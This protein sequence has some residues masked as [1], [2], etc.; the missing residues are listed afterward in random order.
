MN[1]ASKLICIICIILASLA[2]TSIGLAQTTSDECPPEGCP[3][4]GGQNSEDEEYD[5][6]YEEKEYQA[7]QR[8]YYTF[9]VCGAYFVKKAGDN[10]KGYVGPFT[11]LEYRL[12]KVFSFGFDSFYAWL[13]GSGNQYLSV[14]NPGIKIY[15]FMYKNPSFEPFLFFGGHALDMILGDSNLG[16][17]GMAQGGF[18][19]AGFKLMPESAPVGFEF[20]TRVSFLAMQ[21]SNAAGG[22]RG[23]AIPIFGFLGVT[24]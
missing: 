1:M 11:N 15:P 16:K 5:F 20:F 9:G 12:M 13:S 21:R 10:V 18:A 19:G 6:K 23:L 17:T 22:G 14:F 8:M 4:P 2:T 3:P 24:Y 7:Y